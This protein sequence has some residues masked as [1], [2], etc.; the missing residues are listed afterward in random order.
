MIREDPTQHPTTIAKRRAFCDDGGGHGVVPTNPNAHEQSHSKEIPK[1]VPRGTTHMIGQ[2]DDEDDADNHDDHLFAVDEFPAK[3]IPHE[4]KRQLTNDVAD[5]GGRID[6]A[7]QEERVGGSLDGGLGQ[8]A[9]VLVGPY[10]GDQV[11]DE[12]I[13][14]VEEETDTVRQG[15]GVSGLDGGK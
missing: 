8:A 12:E 9:P 15:L 14:G 4:S 10:R 6:G 3:G 1:L 11:D 7:A 5:V 13:V 2:A